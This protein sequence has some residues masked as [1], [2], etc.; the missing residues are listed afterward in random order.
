MATGH[1]TGR[2]GAGR[3]PLHRDRV[4]PRAMN[5]TGKSPGAKAAAPSRLRGYPVM[6]RTIS[7]A[8][9]PFELLGPAD[10]EALIERPEV[11]E[12][13]ARDEYMPYWAELW[14]GAVMLAEEIA[15]W[16]CVSAAPAPRVLELG[17][18]L[19]LAGL[20]AATRG[21]D[22]TC[23]DYD[24]DALA[25]VAASAARLGLA[26]LATRPLDWRLADPA[27]IAER[28]IVADGLYERR[29][30]APILRCIAAQLAPGG[31]AWLSDPGRSTADDFPPTAARAGFRIDCQSSAEIEFNGRAMA[32]RIFVLRR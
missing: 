19:G 32:G 29:N 5:D 15:T 30:L 17:C 7:V 8:G 27:L 28:V 25:F 22:V 13:F 18:G 16:P 3:P 14:P 11:A 4:D 31:T 21:Y 10:F 20:L 2:L 12:R 24:D 23:S 6:L 9:R 1:S 26:N